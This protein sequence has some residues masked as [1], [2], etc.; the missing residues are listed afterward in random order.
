MTSNV[1]SLPLRAVSAGA[2]LI[3]FVML[4]ASGA[5]A[6][7]RGTTGPSR[8]AGGPGRIGGGLPCGLRLLNRK[9]LQRVTLGSEKKALNEVLAATA[10]PTVGLFG[11]CRS[12][13]IFHQAG[14]FDSFLKNGEISPVA[15]ER[16]R[17]SVRGQ[18]AGS[19]LEAFTWTQEGGSRFTTIGITNKHGS[20]TFE[21]ILNSLP[22]SSSHGFSVV[23]PRATAGVAHGMTWITLKATFSQYTHVGLLG[24]R[25]W[26][27]LKIGTRD[28]RSIVRHDQAISFAA[29]NG[30][31]AAAIEKHSV[32]ENG[33]ACLQVSTTIDWVAPLKSLKV[34]GGGNGFNVAIQVVGAIGANGQQALTY[35]LCANGHASSG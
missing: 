17:R 7:D 24:Y 23:N 27:T 16:F 29:S 30:W 21:P 4:F 3:V 13:T 8:A 15:L 22:G 31:T 9:P 5:A 10:I 18:L 2:L 12:L 28:H 19:R 26:E 11:R 6:S 14:G 34:S 25:A 33:V 32:V 35:T 20:L 1:G